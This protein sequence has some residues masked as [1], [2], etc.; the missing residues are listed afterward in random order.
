MYGEK[1]DH[2]IS[3]SLLWKIGIAGFAAANTMMLA[4]SLFQ[5]LFTGITP[6]VERYFQWVSL[7]LTLPAI[8]YS[9]VPFYQTSFAAL[10]Q[11]RFHLDQPLTLAFLSAFL[12]SV[13]NT[14]LGHSYVYYDSVCAL[15]FLLLVGRLLQMQALETARDAAKASWQILTEI[16]R[17]KGRIVPLE[18]L[19]P[20]DIV[21]V[22]PGERF[23]VDGMVIEGES[24]IDQSVL[25]GESIPTKVQKGDAVYAGALN[26]ASQLNIKCQT[27]GEGSRMGKLLLDSKIDDSTF[28]T[29]GERASRYFVPAVLGASAATFFYW[30]PSGTF[31]AVNNALSLLIVTCPC[32]LGIAAPAVMS[33]V[34]GSAAKKG[35]L[36]RKASALEALSDARNICFDKTGTLTTGDFSLKCY[37]LLLDSSDKDIR[38]IKG[39]LR[40]LATIY[41]HHPLSKWA[42]KI[43]D[44]LPFEEDN[45]ESEALSEEKLIPGKGTQATHTSLGI[46]R[47]GSPDWIQE[48]LKKPIEN[49]SKYS[50]IILSIGDK[51]ALAL[52]FEDEIVPGL[53]QIISEMENRKTSL[54]I[55]S[56]DSEDAVMRVASRLGIPRARTFYRVSPEQKIE[57]VRSL[58]PSVAM[59]GDGINDAGALREAT[60]GIGIRGGVEAT[61]ESASVYL[62]NGLGSFKELHR[63]TRRAKRTIHTT[64]WISVIY[65]IGGGVL[66]VLGYMNPLIA[67]I[68]MPLSSLTVISIAIGGSR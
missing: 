51:P 33:L 42:V 24:E 7:L 61:L 11:G 8:I 3:K 63:L 5:G 25:T 23:P 47:L 36:I 30:L 39:L 54:H 41:P 20:G 26:I 49:I 13:V 43:V 56:G 6:D 32:A 15:I 57:I 21:E 1:S 65:N 44:I 37:R 22:L 60:I 40:K 38:I 12:L 19:S 58:K 59:I 9:A 35:I 16:A 29:L 52:S 53:E 45:L 28:A 27:I 46:V 17:H 50:T 66:S 64:L 14:T 4:V 48:E 31:V 18:T 62:L 55:I 68:L 67:A 34:I 10:R 2:E